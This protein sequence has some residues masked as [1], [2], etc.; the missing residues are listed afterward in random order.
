MAL[1]CCGPRLIG[2]T[3][4]YDRID[5]FGFSLL[6]ELAHVDWHWNEE[7]GFIDDMRLPSLD[8]KEIQAV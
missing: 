8:A 2:L 6:H 1:R 4:R 3:L 7:H 5:N